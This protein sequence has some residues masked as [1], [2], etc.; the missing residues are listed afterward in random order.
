V[1]IRV[2]RVEIQSVVLVFSTQLCELL[3]LLPSLWYKSLPLPPSLCEQVY[4]IHVY[5]VYG[6]GGGHWVLGLRQ[7][8]TC[9]EVPLNVNFLDD[10]NLLAF[11][12]NFRVQEKLENM[13][14]SLPH[15]ILLKADSFSDEFFCERLPIPTR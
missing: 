8:N 9:S 2:Y 6:G 14:L 15:R 11:K 13:N 5:S 1:F 4:C 12:A 3:P 10:D 7:I